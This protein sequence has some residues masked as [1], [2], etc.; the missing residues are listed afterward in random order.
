MAS[1]TDVTVCY[2]LGVGPE[3]WG[4]S[5]VMGGPTPD[6]WLYG[7]NR[8]GPETRALEHGELGASEFGGLVRGLISKSRADA[9][10]L[11]LTWDERLAV[12][13]F[14]RS[15]G[16]SRIVSGVIWWTG[17]APYTGR[18]EITRRVLSRCAALWVLSTGQL[19]GVMSRF[20]RTVPLIRKVQ[21]GV[22]V[23]FFTATPP[24]EGLRILSIGTDR[25]R[26]WGMLARVLEAVR[27]ARPHVRATVQGAPRGS[28]PAWVEMAPWMTHAD[29]KALYARSSVVVLPT[30]PNLHV[31][32][33]TASCEAQAC[34]RPVVVCDTPG[35]SDYVRPGRTGITIA[36]S[37]VRGMSSAVI[38]L[39]DSEAE[40]ATMGLN[41]RRFA[42][43]KLSSVG[44][45]HEL[46]NLLDDVPI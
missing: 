14:T 32:G 39:L 35:V 9:R 42:E 4:D 15:K 2:P 11:C 1:R 6:H 12:R 40:R 44:M 46:R 29:L 36:P 43:R 22:D 18:S 30:K 24:G 3:R 45:V 13:Q 17:T 41:A 34:G 5:R 7:L 37:D 33:M 19:D 31:S 20:G 23:E 21:F 26:D 25:H 38:D 27:I 10:S 28:M 16:R 8:L